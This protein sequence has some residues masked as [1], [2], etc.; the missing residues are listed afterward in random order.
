MVESDE[1]V[2]LGKVSTAFGIKGWVKIHSYT[3]PLDNLLHYKELWITAAPGWRKIDLVEGRP[4][5]RGLIGRFA[6]CND[7][8]QALSYAGA[9]LAVPR[10]ALPQLEAGD[11]Y[12]SQLEGLKV[13]NSEGELLGWVDHLLE[14][15][16]NDVLVVRPGESSIDDQERLI[17]YLPGRVV[18]RVDLEQAELHV[19]WSADF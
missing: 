7:R 9:E 6:G 11:Y 1:W 18:V 17:P 2:V 5:G 15:G 8:D 12:W 16:A 4:Q 13:I 3:E 10:S 19:D 14:T